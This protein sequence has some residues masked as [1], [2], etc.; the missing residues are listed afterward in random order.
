MTNAVMDAFFSTL[1]SQL[2]DRFESCS[3]A[4]REFVDYIEL[5]YNQHESLTNTRINSETARAV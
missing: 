1:K 2:A 4:K 3:V 5:F